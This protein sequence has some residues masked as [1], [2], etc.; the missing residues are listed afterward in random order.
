M[1]AVSEFTPQD[2]SKALQAKAL[3]AFGESAT[4]SFSVENVKQHRADITYTVSA[5]YECK[6]RSRA[7]SQATG[8]LYDP[9]QI[10]VVL[11]QRQTELLH[12]PGVFRERMLAKMNSN[13]DY[14]RYHAN[15]LLANDGEV[16]C[17][18]EDCQSCSGRGKVNCSTCEGATKHTCR[19]CGGACRMRCSSCSGTGNTSHSKYCTGCGGSG[20]NSNGRCVFCNGRGVAGSTC[21]NCHGAGTATCR[22]CNGYGQQNC[23]D[24][25]QGKVTCKACQG[26]CQ[27]IYEYRLDIYANTK[28]RYSWA[29]VTVDWLVPAIRE[30]MNCEE[31][32]TVFSVDTYKEASDDP[33]VFTGYGQVIAAQADV[34]YE[35][36]TADCH[37]IGPKLSAV[38]LNGI[39]S[40]SFKKAV[41]GVQDHKNFKAV[42]EAS[43]SKIARQL[44]SEDGKDRNKGV[45]NFSPV[46]KGII[47]S[48]DAKKFL[49]GRGLSYVHIITEWK[50]FRWGAVLSYAHSLTWLFIGLF[51][52]MSILH[53]ET[54][55]GL[56]GVKV[57]LGVVAAVFHPEMVW[58]TMTLPLTNLWYIVI[59]LNGYLHL[60]LWMV[61]TAIFNCFAQP[62]LFPGWWVI[63][64]ESWA[65]HLVSSFF[66]IPVLAFFM[67]LFPGGFVNMDLSQ[68]IPHLSFRPLVVLSWII[69]FVPQIFL[70]ALTISMIRYKAAGRHWALRGLRILEQ[71]KDVYGWLKVLV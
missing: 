23:N 55:D 37:F 31:R 41:T 47:S 53:K 11:G 68:L 10:G 51:G 48:D 12:Y 46:R 34:S 59:H 56:S 6:S 63:T 29:N 15:F 58:D 21:Y 8:A 65:G 61:A 14:Y 69:I 36:A 24:C 22:G 42:N 60:A 5:S 25:F 67:G 62:I 44:I 20:S 45:E 32:H 17:S 16:C 4:S 39:L 33:Y 54:P 9:S 71:K 2:I 38:Q 35:G 19:Q 7:V 1:T 57:M 3:D 18:I 52:L 50:K 66:G 26:A 28:V 27:L 13:L 49:H 40:G 43:S 70:L 64:K 30:W